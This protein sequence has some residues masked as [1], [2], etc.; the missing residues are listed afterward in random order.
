M[1][2]TQ[3]PTETVATMLDA[4]RDSGLDDIITEIQSQI[5]AWVAG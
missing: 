1:T 2:G 5:D 3:D 4:M